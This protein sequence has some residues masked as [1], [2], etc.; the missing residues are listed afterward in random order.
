MSSR[1]GTVVAAAVLAIVGT[2]LGCS[3]SPDSTV[4]SFYRALGKG[5]ITEAKSYISAQIVG[6]LG[7]AKL[8]AA[9]SSETE[10]IRACGGIK[11]V[12]VKLDGAGEVRAGVATVSYAGQCRPKA[13]RVKLIKEDG[14]WKLGADK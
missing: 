7:D 11:S 10:K 5:E 13:E 1:R 6:M 3:K 14:K 9:L 4:E 2:L 12:N 8:S